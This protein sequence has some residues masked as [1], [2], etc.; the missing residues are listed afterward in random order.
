MVTTLVLY[1]YS[2]FSLCFR[3]LSIL[4][5]PFRRLVFILGSIVLV[6]PTGLLGLLRRRFTFLRSWLLA[7]VIFVARFRV[8][9]TTLP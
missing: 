7:I 3:L 5:A 1:P 4:L 8:S 6:V 9:L 2:S